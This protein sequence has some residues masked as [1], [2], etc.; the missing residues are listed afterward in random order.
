MRK[1]FIELFH[2]NCRELIYICTYLLIIPDKSAR[3]ALTLA[4]DFTMHSQDS[5]VD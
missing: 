5:G 2:S 3:K 1:E 4:A